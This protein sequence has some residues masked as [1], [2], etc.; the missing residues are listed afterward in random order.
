VK[1]LSPGTPAQ[2]LPRDVVAGYHTPPSLR[3]IESR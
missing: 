1:P 2:G 3:G